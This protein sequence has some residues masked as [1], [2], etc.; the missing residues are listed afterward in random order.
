MDKG[1]IKIATKVLYEVNQDWISTNCRIYRWPS[2][3][4]VFKGKYI[5]WW[6]NFSFYMPGS[7]NLAQKN[8]FNFVVLGF[9]AE[10]C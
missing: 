7:K 9:K 6:G 1:R 2:T 4:R 3:A 10:T 5:C 8:N